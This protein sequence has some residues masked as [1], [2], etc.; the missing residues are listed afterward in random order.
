MTVDKKIELEARL[1]NFSEFS[2]GARE[3]LESLSECPECAIKLA[4]ELVDSNDEEERKAL[5][6]VL[7]NLGRAIIK[8]RDRREDYGSRASSFPR[9]PLIDA[10]LRGEIGLGLIAKLLQGREE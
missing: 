3:F 6:E 10:W 9:F 4:L 1:K 8:Q 7:I 5:K 2:V